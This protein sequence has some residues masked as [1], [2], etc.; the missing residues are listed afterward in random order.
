MSQNENNLDPSTQ[1]KPVYADGVNINKIGGES[2][3][4]TKIAVNRGKPNEWTDT[5]D[6]GEDGLTEY[7][8]ITTDEKF[9]LEYKGEV[10]P[11]N[12]FYITPAQLKQINQPNFIEALEA[13]KTLGPV[14]AI[15]RP[16]KDNPTQSY[17]AFAY[18][19]DDD[20]TK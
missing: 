20:F 8:T 16:K 11:I 10:K 6:V 17:W 18:S 19:T 1:P 5:K 3:Y 7:R 14:Q 13:G 12:N 2:I 4:I 15:K 9:D